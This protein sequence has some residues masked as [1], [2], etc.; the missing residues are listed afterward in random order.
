MQLH[1][2]PNH[3]STSSFLSDICSHFPPG[4]LAGFCGS[5]KGALPLFNQSGPSSWAPAPPRKPHAHI[6][7]K[8]QPLRASQQTL[9]MLHLFVYPLPTCVGERA[10][11]SE[12]TQGLVLALLYLGCVWPGSSHLTL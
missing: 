12:V 2:P 3:V 1:G 9:N 4:V 5:E 11:D 8:N 7:E 6:E 10:Q